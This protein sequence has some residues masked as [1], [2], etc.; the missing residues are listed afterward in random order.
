MGA[1]AGPLVIGWVM[2][3]M[4]PPG[5]FVLIAALLVALTAYAAYRMTQR[6]APA[7]ETTG[8]YAP[9]LPSASP[10]AMEVAQEYFIERSEED[11]E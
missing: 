3:V 2:Q 8:A 1:I 10:V 6:P 11:E 9:V 7:V 5:F 4:G